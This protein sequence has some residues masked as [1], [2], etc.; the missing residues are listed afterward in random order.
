MRSLADISKERDDMTTL[1]EITSAFEGIASMRISQIKDLVQQSE[2]FFADL[3]RIYSQLRVDALFHFGRSQT[4]GLVNP[5]VLFILITSEGSLSGDIDQRLITE[6][7]SHYDPKKNDVLVVG[8]HGAIQLAQRDI[9]YTREFKMPESD[10]NI[11]V[12]PIVLEV[13]KYS[14]TTIF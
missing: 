6:A 5:K 2:S 4:Q 10:R 13:Q 8:H 7:V 3:W 12:M 9:P 14:S 1:L 11:N